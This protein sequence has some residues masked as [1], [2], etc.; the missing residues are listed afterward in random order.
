MMGAAALLSWKYPTLPGS[1]LSHSDCE[2]H[3]VVSASSI[4]KALI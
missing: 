3:G 4:G 1:K 2:Q